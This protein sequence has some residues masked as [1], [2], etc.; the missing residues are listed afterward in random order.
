MIMRPPRSNSTDTLVPYT[1]LF[2]SQQ[3]EP[4]EFDER[5]LVQALDQQRTLTAALRSI[6][7]SPGWF[8]RL[9]KSVIAPM[10]TRSDEAGLAQ[11]IL[12]QGARFATDAVVDMIEV[13]WLPDPA[14]DNGA[15]QDIG[16]EPCRDRVCQ[17]V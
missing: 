3:N 10:M 13:R 12:S 16:R 6:A 1:T 5:I 15:M 7:G 4:L 17:Y 2:R 11:Y 8:K 9:G 14:F